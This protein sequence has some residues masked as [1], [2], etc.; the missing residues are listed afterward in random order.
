MGVTDN[1]TNKKLKFIK[2]EFLKKAREK[3]LKKLTNF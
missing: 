3:Y 2:E 1:I